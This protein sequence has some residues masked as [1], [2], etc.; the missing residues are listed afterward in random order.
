M[1]PV[2]GAYPTGDAYPEG[3]GYPEGTSPGSSPANPTPGAG[4][5]AD[6]RYG[7]GP[8]TADYADGHADPR[9]GGRY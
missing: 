1:S 3:R 2:T 9:R 5:A 8:G 6:A 4:Q 7:Y